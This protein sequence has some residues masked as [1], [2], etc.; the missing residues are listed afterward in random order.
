M[1]LLAA[2]TIEVECSMARTYDFASNLEYFPEWFP[3]VVAIV[4]GNDMPH[5]SP[6]KVYH[7]IVHVPLRGSRRVRVRVVQAEPPRSLITEGDLPALLPRMEIRVASLAENRCTLEWRMYS[8]RRS[9]W[10]RFFVLPLAARIMRRR[11]PHGLARLKA[12]LE[13]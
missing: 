9:G 6:G 12:L 3:G 8:R 11:V 10:S 4:P 7:E 2:G 13:A 5:G 1:Y